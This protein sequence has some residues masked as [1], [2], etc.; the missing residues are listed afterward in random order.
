MKKILSYLRIRIRSLRS[1]IKR[2]VRSKIFRKT[3]LYLFAGFIVVHGI[4]ILLVLTGVFG[5]LPLASDL[6]RIQNPVATEIYTADSVLM[7]KYYMQ[8]RQYLAPGQITASHR[9]ILIATEDRRFYD[10]HGIDFRSLGRVVIK[11]ILLRRGEAGGGSTISQQLAKNL[12]PRQDYGLISMPVNKLREM[13]IAVRM[14]NI[15]AKE[16]ILELYLGTVPFGENT[17]GIRSA[18]IRFFNKEPRDLKVEETAVLI[19]MLKATGIY[20]PIRYP[21]KARIRRNIVLGQMARYNYLD[22][23]LADSLQQLPL[24][25]DYRPL[26]HDAGIAPYFREF[27]RGELDQWCRTNLKNDSEHYDLYTDGLKVYTTID[28]RL[29]KYA[30]EA[31][32]EH[33][34]RLQELFDEHWRNWDLWK[35]IR[36]DMLLINYDG[37][38]SKEMATEETR[39]MD[40][41]TWK[42]LQEREFNT[43]DS[44]RHYLKFLQAGFMAMD[45]RNSEIKAWVGG[46][47]YEYFKYDHVLA[48]RQVG[49]TFKPLV[50]LAA[51]EQGMSPCDFYPNDSVVYEEYDDWTPRNA[52]RT[53][54]GYYSLKGALVH[55][56]NTVSVNLL[57]EAGIDTVMALG[58]KA[59]IESSM[60]EVPSLALGTANISLYEMMRVYQAIANKGMAVK[61]RYL[62]RIEDKD[63]EVL[64]EAPAGEQGMDICHPENAEVMIEM[65]RDVVNNGTANALRH[66]HRIVADVAGKTGTTQNHT[67]G[68]FIGFTPSLVAGVWVGGDLQNL[69]FRSIDYGQGA[70]MAM[71]V[72][73][74]FMK[75][76][77]SDDYWAN[78]QNEEFE[79]SESTKDM[80]TCDD[81]RERKP[82]QFRPFKKLKEK[83]LLKKL[84]KRKKK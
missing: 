62:A 76:T 47:N 38:Y 68:W 31:V 28:S 29:Q 12:Y 22:R 83:S 67:D 73:S 52:D 71:P 72:W 25:L 46:I 19:G 8:N 69:R 51:L 66:E 70:F 84:F 54:G 58:Q 6:T 81:F 30:E 35:G 77:F 57:M 40:V 79:I 75:R 7:G 3:L 20:N 45:V 50:Y 14:E 61:P 39:K 37:I 16:E 2:L 36:E 82:F 63:G 42:G 5:K 41:F 65:L 49:S 55:S 24:E 11:T 64:Y 15:Y 18:S 23:A 1:H 48:K 78:L 74:N 13:A 26:P 43:L 21:E 4:F 56:V 59:G 10:H 53:Y 9:N 32:Q 27:L 60:P 80:L 17:F 33:M 34:A 44:I